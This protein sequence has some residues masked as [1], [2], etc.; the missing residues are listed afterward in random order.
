MKLAATLRGT[1]FRFADLKE[2]LA[3]AN[4]E[5]S[6]DKLAGVAAASATERVAAKL[7]LSEVTLRELRENPVVPYD[8]DAV[9]R[10]IQDDLNVPIYEGIKHWTVAKL[11]EHVL[12]ET[13]SGADLLRLSRGLTSEMIAACAKLMS[14]L[15]LM[16]VAEFW[17]PLE[18]NVLRAYLESQGIFVHVWGEHL[19]VTHIF[20]SAASGG[21]RLQVPRDQVADAKEVIA[22]FE[23]GDFAIEETPE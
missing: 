6:G 13:V 20:L 12:D 16:T 10:L 17:N 8:E 15:D 11:R 3:K 18:A 2:V 1:T 4:E 9:T 22:A 5:K 7:V 21:I 14:N 23:R 19:G